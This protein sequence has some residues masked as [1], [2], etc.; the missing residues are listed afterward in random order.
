MMN[1]LNKQ[2]IR[3]LVAAAK[4]IH[5]EKNYAACIA[6]EDAGGSEWLVE[7]YAEF[8]GFSPYQDWPGLSYCT[9]PSRKDSALLIMLLL[10]FAFSE[11]EVAYE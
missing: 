10:V 7:R 8:Y 9:Y 5:L 2:E 11:A 6:I 4:R 1:R 3:A